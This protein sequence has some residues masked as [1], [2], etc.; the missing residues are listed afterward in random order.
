MVDRV[1]VPVEEGISNTP[2]S[3]NTENKET[4]KILGKFETQAD[5]EKAYQEL[6]SK[7]TK[8]RQSETK[9]SESKPTATGK[10][11]AKTEM[12]DKPEV[13]DKSDK[14]A[15][16]EDVKSILPGFDENQIM[17]FSNTA[18]ENGALTDDQYATLEKQGYSREIVDQ[19]IQGQFA[20]VE[21]QKDSLINAGGGEQAVEA[22]FDW[23]AKNLPE[24][25]VERY[26]SKFAEGGADALMAMEHLKSR[27]S[28]SG[29]GFGFHG[30][31]RV[32]GANTPGED[33]SVYTSTAQVT[34]DMNSQEYKTD[35]AFRAKV[36]AKIGR[37]KVL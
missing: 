1:Q 23:A 11:D 33:T 22:M 28:E 32:H 5:L 34:K 31:G 6:E 9:P 19:Y 17:E 30:G 24:A 26:N 14:P 8:E 4:G 13:E 2:T 10:P 12:F 7:F 25:E 16:L 3:D 20:L 18:W 15:T 36:A 35:P 27:F 29:E 21:Q 37:S